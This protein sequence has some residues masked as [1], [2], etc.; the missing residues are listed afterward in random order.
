MSTL[1]F[2]N[3][4]MLILKRQLI[5]SRKKIEKKIGDSKN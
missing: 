5:V 2:L 1:P 3:V 4:D